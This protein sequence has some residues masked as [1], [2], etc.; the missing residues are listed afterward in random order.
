M[1][2]QEV[3]ATTGASGLPALSTAID[4]CLEHKDE[5]APIARALA[6]ADPVLQRH[7]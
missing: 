6:A 1:S 4:E 7:V 3:S 2:G 5:L